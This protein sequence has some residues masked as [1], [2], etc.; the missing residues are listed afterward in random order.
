VP[1]FSFRLASGADLGPPVQGVGDGDLCSG[2][3]PDIGYGELHGTGY[4]IAA[5]VPKV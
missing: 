3:D 4:R 1:E 2:A 5:V